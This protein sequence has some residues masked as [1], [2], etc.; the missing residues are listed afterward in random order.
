MFEGLGLRTFFCIGF[1]SFGLM[2]TGF[3]D[4]GVVVPCGARCRQSRRQAYR[5]LRLALVE[6]GLSAGGESPAP[7]KWDRFYEW[8]GSCGVKVPLKV[9][10]GT[11]EG[12]RGLCTRDRQEAGTELLRIPKDI[13]IDIRMVARHRVAALWATE[14]IDEQF[15]LALWLLA[16]LQEGDES[17]YAPYIQLLPNR[18]MFD[19]QGGPLDLWSDDERAQLKY[20][21]RNCG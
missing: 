15:R 12:I 21:K 8:L 18:A 4:G 1:S 19:D 11:F 6:L 14:R 2:K 9:A 20:E 16:E 10:M 7:Y 17:A 5:T 3:A 13:L